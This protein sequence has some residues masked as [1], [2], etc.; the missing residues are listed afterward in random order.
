[1]NI[2]S[3]GQIPFS[4]TVTMYLACSQNIPSQNEKFHNSLI[5]TLCHGYCIVAVHHEKGLVPAFFK[6]SVYHL[7]GNLEFEE[8]NY[9]L[10]KKS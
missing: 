9:C 1:M 10:G 6:V 5:S 2:F 3:L 8:I 4:H 7:F